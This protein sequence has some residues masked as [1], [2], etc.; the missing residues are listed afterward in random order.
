MNCGHS[1][2]MLDHIKMA[3]LRAKSKETEK[4]WLVEDAYGFYQWDCPHCP[5][6]RPYKVVDMSKQ[7]VAS[8]RF[9][10]LRIV[11]RINTSSKSDSKRMGEE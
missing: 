1:D 11:H 7:A 4:P 6:Y 8:A 2:G 10:H 5:D 9:N 3:Q